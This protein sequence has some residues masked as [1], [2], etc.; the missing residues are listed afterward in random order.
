M[1][2]SLH[3]LHRDDAGAGEALVAIDKPP[4]R[5]VIP[6]RGAA[7][8]EP[9]LQA[10]VA[11]ALGR[12]VFVVHR[13]D[14]GTSGV[15]VFALTAEAHRALSLAF[16]RHAVDKTY[17]ALCRGRLAGGGE[18]DRALVPIRGGRVRPARDGEAGGKPSRSRWRALEQ[19]EGGDARGGGDGFTLVEWRPLQGRLHQVRVHA[20]VLG[21]PLAVDPHY[22]GAEELRAGDDLLLARVPLH[23]A[24][25]S[26][27]HPTTGA[28]VVFESPL[29]DDMQRALAALRG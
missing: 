28:R 20:A 2:S 10:E 22:G 13:L 26:L 15:L 12:R 18:V 14:R 3:W 24:S 6:G 11:E 5:I 1:A 17:L 27:A 29:P 23:A 19:F 16:E 9:T 8:S 21:H 25:L 4:G 7:A